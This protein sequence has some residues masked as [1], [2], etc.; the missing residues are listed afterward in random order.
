MFTSLTL[1]E[2][3]VTSDNGRARYTGLPP[4]CVKSKVQLREGVVLSMRLMETKCTGLFVVV[5]LKIVVYRKYFH[6]RVNNSTDNHTYLFSPIR[7][8]S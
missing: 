4:P 8:W 6:G 1:S 2:Y 7:G 3:K 5:F